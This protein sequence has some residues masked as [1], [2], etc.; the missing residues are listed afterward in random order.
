[1]S[2]PRLSLA[3]AALLAAL[4]GGAAAQTTGERGAS[5][6]I[7]PKIVTDGSADTLVQLVN[8]TGSRVSAFCSYVDGLD[9]WAVASFALTLEPRQPLSWT[10][11][12]G[13]DASG[14][15]ENAVPAAPADLRGEL[16]CVE[17]DT[18]GAPA[19]DNRLAGHATGIAHADGDA[20]SYAA[21]GLRGSG[22]NDGDETLC[23]GGTPSDACILAE[24]DACPGEWIIAH[25][26]EG[27]GQPQGDA[28]LT[29][30]FAIAPCSQNVRDAEPTTVDIDLEVTNAFAERF[31][32]SASV[33]CWADLS[34]AEIGDG[35]FAR[36]T[37]GS[38]A[39]QTRLRPAAGSGG[40]VLSAEVESRDGAGGPVRSRSGAPA[41]QRGA[42][43]PDLIV[44]P[45]G[46]P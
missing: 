12:R 35:L 46:R 39:I 1:M 4:A 45:M 26:S 16:V 37:L 38:D 28:T 29:T 27:A 34:L 6:L 24:Y 30:R 3:L 17:T 2:T 25:A 8:L 43:Q 7:Y 40:F 13:R 19:S 33:R 44:L 32:G 20:A 14:G 10:A 41:H 23:I 15:G 36:G 42:A 21:V 18:A 5:I 31:T 9:G 22:F 11:A